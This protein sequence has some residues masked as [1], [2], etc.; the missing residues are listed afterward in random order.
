MLLIANTELAGS[1][2]ELPPTRVCH[3]KSCSCVCAPFEECVPFE[4][5]SRACAPFEE[6]SPHVSHSR[7]PPHS[8][9]AFEEPSPLVQAAAQTSIII[10][11]TSKLGFNMRAC[12]LRA[13][14]AAMLPRG[15]PAERQR[16]RFS[17]CC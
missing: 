10:L 2:G 5:L 16:R 4:E 12:L 8:C 11:Q 3:L 9:A 15:I 1:A 7:S 14:R 6:P 17:A 13:P